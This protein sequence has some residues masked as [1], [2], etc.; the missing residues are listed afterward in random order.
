MNEGNL[1]TC[2]LPAPLSLSLA[3]TLYLLLGQPRDRC[4]SGINHVLMIMN[5]ADIF[6]WL[7]LLLCCFSF[8]PPLFPR[9]SWPL[10]VVI[11]SRCVDQGNH[12]CWKVCISCYAICKRVI[13]RCFLSSTLQTPYFHPF[14]LYR[15]NRE[16]ERESP[17]HTITKS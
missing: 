15:H 10:I 7:D 14:G 3:L 2:V 1:L 16:R 12:L 5:R 6:L 9:G 4:I 13:A 11:R 8:P 17:G